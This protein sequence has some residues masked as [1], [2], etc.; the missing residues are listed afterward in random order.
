V[1]FAGAT[2]ALVWAHQ[3]GRIGNAVLVGGL[4]LLVAVDLGRADRPFIQ[5]Y[6]FL[7]WSAPDPNDQFLRS[8]IGEEDPFR[9]I[10]FRNAQNVEL[11]MHGLDLVTGHHPNDLARY[12]TLLG[13]QGSQAQALN[14]T[15]PVVLRILNTRYL[16]WPETAQGGPPGDIQALSRI[17][18]PAGV[19]AV[20]PYPGLGRAWFVGSHTVRD[21]DAALQRL[22]REPFDPTQE[23]ILAEDPGVGSGGSTPAHTITWLEYNPDERVVRLETNG[24]GFLVISENWHPGWRVW[25]A[26]SEEPLRRANYALGAVVIPQAGSFEVRMQY[27]APQVRRWGLISLGALLLTV[28]LCLTAVVPG[29]KGKGDGSERDEG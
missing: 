15:H 1:L 3:V 5:T 14:W 28:G 26:G 2:A 19:E 9:V 11:A 29:R 27:V 22:L 10:D 4:V 13:L 23:V 20:Y 18:G 17:Q 8:R 12:R 16:L 24:P 25:V 7:S 21:D 6:D